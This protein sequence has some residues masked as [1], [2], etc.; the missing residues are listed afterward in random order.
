MSRIKYWSIKHYDTGSGIW[1]SDTKIPRAGVESFTRT[2]EATIQF[3]DLVD[4]SQAKSST[5]THANWGEIVLVF[6]R[7]FV[8]SSMKTQL[9]NYI[10]QEKGV[11]ISM[12]TSSGTSSY[13]EKV[14]EGY[15][16]KYEETWE[17]TGKTQ[18][19]VVKLTLKEFDVG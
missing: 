6:P 10:T 4:G 8:T 18:E 15:L 13:T 9:N 19:Y 17:L 16:M 14:L 1:I 3:I 7:Y 5:E 12:P 2:Q 11:Q